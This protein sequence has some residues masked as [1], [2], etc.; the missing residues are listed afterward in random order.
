MI[1]KIAETPN[2]GDLTQIKLLNQCF[3]IDRL[4]DIASKRSSDKQTE[5]V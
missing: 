3:L 2:L 5:S 4:F 1:V